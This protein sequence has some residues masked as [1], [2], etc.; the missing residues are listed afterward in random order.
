[1]P[2]E[3]PCYPPSHIQ[4]LSP[5]VEALLAPVIIEHANSHLDTFLAGETHPLLK[6]SY[7]PSIVVNPFVHSRTNPLP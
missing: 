5:D 3:L 7:F 4:A 1:M 2:R 6:S